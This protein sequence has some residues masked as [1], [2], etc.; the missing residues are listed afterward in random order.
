MFE[1]QHN[2][3]NIHITKRYNLHLSSIWHVL[4]SI[5]FIMTQTDTKSILRRQRI[6]EMLASA[7]YESVIALSRALA[8]SDMTIRRDLQILERDGAVR[9][10][11]GGAV[12]EQVPEL[13]LAFHVRR[14]QQTQAKARIARHAASQVSDGAVVYLDAGT[15]VL[16]MAEALSQRRNLTIVTPS[17][18]LINCLQ[19]NASPGITAILLG[20]TVRPDLMSVIGPLAE[21]NLATFHFDLAVLGTGGYDQERGLTLSTMEEI[22]LKKTA[23]RL[24]D[25]VIV[26]ATREKIGRTGMI[27]FL[28]PDEIDR[29]IVDEDPGTHDPLLEVV[30]QAAAPH[31][32]R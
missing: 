17:V 7:N 27:Y 28:P 4:C 11:H 1:L 23:A 21:Q 13:S 19:L 15:S 18:A 16:A 32:A 12:S 31:A 20:G 5:L 30:P 9:R 10:T 25:R 22:P 3:V 26:L 6:L 24:A 8:V 14:Q 2:H 29:I